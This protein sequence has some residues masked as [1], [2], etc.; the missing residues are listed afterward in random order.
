MQQSYT[1]ECD[2]HGSRLG[3]IICRHILQ[4]RDHVV[5]FIENSDDP[6]D[7]QAWCNACEAFFQQEGGLTP[8][9]EKFSDCAVVCD[10]CYRSF[11]A[12]QT[13]TR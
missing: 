1:L 5:G 11:K 7:L 10:L 13:T 9:F 4:A 8:A 3:A 12:Q 6:Q 2:T